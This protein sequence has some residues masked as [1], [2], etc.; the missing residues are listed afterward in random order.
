ME[1]H[2]DRHASFIFLVILTHAM[3]VS[4]SLY[5]TDLPSI[6]TIY[7]VYVNGRNTFLPAYQ[8]AAQNDLW[9]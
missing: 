2:S 8:S 4:C 6:N 7:T 5:Y 1:G 9:Y 3:H